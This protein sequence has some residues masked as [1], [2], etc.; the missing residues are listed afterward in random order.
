[1]HGLRARRA[2][3]AEELLDDEIALRRRLS[4]E[5]ERLVGGA[6]RAARRGRRPSR[7]RPTEAELAQ[8]PEDADRDLAAVGDEDVGEARHLAAYSPRG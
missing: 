2:S 5:R 4:A 8:R 1:M 7:P 3:R 6:A